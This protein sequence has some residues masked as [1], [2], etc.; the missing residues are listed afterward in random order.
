MVP[1]LGHSRVGG[2]GGGG[3]ETLGSF[4]DS[5]DVKLPPITTPTKDNIPTSTIHD[6]RVEALASSNAEEFAFNYTVPSYSGK[7]SHNL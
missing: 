1:H 5:V 3:A 6:V 2:G 7:N 4:Y